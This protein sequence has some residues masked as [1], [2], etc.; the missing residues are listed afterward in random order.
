[1][2][3]W[4]SHLVAHSEN[5]RL[6]DSAFAQIMEKGYHTMGRRED[7]GVACG[8]VASNVSCIHRCSRCH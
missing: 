1:M 2:L 5:N 3:R 6:S 7:L 4:L 8:V